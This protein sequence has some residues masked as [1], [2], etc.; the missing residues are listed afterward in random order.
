MPTRSVVTTASALALALLTATATFAQTPAPAAKPAM[1]L[2]GDWNV[3]LYGDHVVPVGMT[4]TQDAKKLTGTIMLPGTDVALTG[5]FVDGAITLKGKVESG[6]TAH[7]P[8]MGTG[9]VTITATVK[10]DGTLNGQFAGGRGTIKLTAERLG[11]RP[12]RATPPP[13][14]PGVSGSVAGRSGGGWA[15]S[16]RWGVTSCA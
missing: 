2:T 15:P 12:S 1:T 14:D 16:G 4:L 7:G 3:S 5:D 13:A 9:D 8:G 10:E 11:R 6:A